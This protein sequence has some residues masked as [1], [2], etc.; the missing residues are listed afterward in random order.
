[1]T[2]FDIA[3]LVIALLFGLLGL[4]K[5]LLYELLLLGLTA[6]VFFIAY[7]TTPYVLEILNKF[8]IVDER[9]VFPIFFS[10]LLSISLSLLGGFIALLGKADKPAI[11]SRIIGGVLGAFL[12]VLFAGM[13]LWIA[14]IFFPAIEKNLNESPIARFAMLTVGETYAFLDRVIRENNITPFT[15]MNFKI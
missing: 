13:L 12:G 6:V 1:M 7:F 14:S 3:A 5:A 4:R 9:V 11:P 10:V 15:I 2:S 8:I